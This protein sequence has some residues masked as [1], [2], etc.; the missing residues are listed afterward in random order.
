MDAPAGGETI[1]SREVALYRAVHS[2]GLTYL[3]LPQA[4][5]L[6][7][8][9]PLAKSGGSSPPPATNSA[10]DIHG[11]VAMLSGNFS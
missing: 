5:A 8:E 3:N 6:A 10:T 9:R 7:A 2:H 4:W 1:A 11:V